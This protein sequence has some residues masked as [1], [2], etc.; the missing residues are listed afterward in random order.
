MKLAD[1][2]KDAY[3]AAV[4]VDETS[5]GGEERDPSDQDE[6]DQR[7]LRP[8]NPLFYH[9]SLRRTARAVAVCFFTAPLFCFIGR[10]EICISTR[11]TDRRKTADF[12]RH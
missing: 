8:S 7:F 10:D 11:Q 4:E 3:F 12:M 1:G 5:G 9:P 6:K 2:R